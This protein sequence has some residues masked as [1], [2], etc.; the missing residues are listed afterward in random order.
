MGFSSHFHNSFEKLSFICAS[1]FM[2]SPYAFQRKRRQIHSVWHFSEEKSPNCQCTRI[3]V[4]LLRWPFFGNGKHLHFKLC[5]A[6][7]KNAADQ[8]AHCAHWCALLGCSEA[9][10]HLN[11]RATNATW[12]SPVY[13][14]PGLDKG[15][16]NRNRKRATIIAIFRNG[17]NRGKLRLRLPT[18]RQAI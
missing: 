5:S 1:N 18:K 11:S 13:G 17:T 2:I 12:K 7:V 10:A 15:T 14:A 4:Q 3:W 6:S 9:T 8:C 16:H